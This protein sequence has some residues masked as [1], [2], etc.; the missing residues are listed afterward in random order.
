MAPA[1]VLRVERR[2]PP[3]GPSCRGLFEACQRGRA[4]C[5]HALLHNEADDRWVGP[6]ASQRCKLSWVGRPGWLGRRRGRFCLKFLAFPGASLA[7]RPS[8][9]SPALG[10]VGFPHCQLV[11]VLN[12]WHRVSRGRES[13]LPLAFH[14]NGAQGLRSRQCR[15]SWASNND[16]YRTP[17]RNFAR[18]ART[19]TGARE[20][21]DPPESPASLPALQPPHL[22]SAV[23]RVRDDNRRL[24]RAPR[25][26]TSAAR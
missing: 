15:G 20:A 9:L 4:C 19:A 12:K 24:Q 1:G 13:P 21:G 26:H 16:A 2:T 17:Y 10:Q 3:V 14:V 18:L 7:S 23:V 25:R 22:P 5:W 6:A 8:S 11:S